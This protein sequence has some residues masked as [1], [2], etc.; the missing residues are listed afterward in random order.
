M[1]AELVVPGL[2]GGGDG[3]RVPA[4]ELLFARGRRKDADLQTLEDWVREAFELGGDAFPAGALSVLASGASAGAE[5]WMRADPVH[6]RV[7]Q[8]RA[9]VMPA[10]ALELSADEA[11]ALCEALNGHFAGME[12]TPFQARRWY[13]RLPQTALIDAGHPLQSAGR[14]A[15]PPAH[16]AALLTEAQMVLHAHPVNEAREARGAPPVN[17][18]WLWGGGRA[19]SARARWQSVAADD[20]AVL[21]AARLAGAR[22]RSLPGSAGEWLERVPEDGRQLAVLDVLRAPLAFGNDVTEEIA[23]L[24]RDWFAPLLAALRAGRIGMVTIHVP[25]AAQA[26]SFETIRGDLRRFWRRRKPIKELA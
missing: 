22:H 6:L 21:G 10:E 9:V 2:L 19:V 1:H 24:E 14:D 5:A 4:L 8:D 7:M 3:P 18:L 15:E 26:V 13:A 25:D 12:F 23:R 20:P 11:R 17:S 16:A